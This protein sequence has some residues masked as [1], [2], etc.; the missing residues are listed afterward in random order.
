MLKTYAFHNFIQRPPFG[1]TAKNWF[2][3]SFLTPA[4]IAAY[5]NPIL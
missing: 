3:A 4:D 5:L 2:W 1:Q